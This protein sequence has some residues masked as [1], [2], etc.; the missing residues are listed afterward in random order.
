MYSRLDCRSVGE[1]PCQ[2]RDG[3]TRDRR[4]EAGAVERGER[5]ALA[6][7]ENDA[8]PRDP[9]RLLAV[10]EV[11][12]TSR[13]LNVSGPSSAESSSSGRPTSR[14]ATAPGVRRRI[15]S[16]ASRSIGSLPLRPRPQGS[17]FP[18]FSS[19]SS[20]RP[21]R[22]VCSGV[23]AWPVSKASRSFLGAAITLQAE[24]IDVGGQVSSL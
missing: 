5:P 3:P 23:V 6:V 17:A 14:A 4:P 18:V 20:Q 9:V 16:V 19:V 1:A 10:D 15:A 13:G 21:T 8:D 22:S 7:L 12:Q 24:Y 11:T 2:L